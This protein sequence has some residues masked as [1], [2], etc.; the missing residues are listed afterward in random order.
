MR[1][2]KNTDTKNKDFDYKIVANGKCPLCG[3]PLNGD[4]IF[5]CK[6]CAKI[7]SERRSHESNT[8]RD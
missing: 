1:I 7:E 4:K 6:K 3:K 2:N 8:E 5:I